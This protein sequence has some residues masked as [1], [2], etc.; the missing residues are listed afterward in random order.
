MIPKG[1]PK[2]LKQSLNVLNKIQGK[3]RVMVLSY[4]GAA[5][6]TMTFLP[7]KEPADLNHHWD[8]VRTL[9]EVPPP[10]GH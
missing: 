5:A 4:C 10:K 2:Q 1:L 3:T 8:D 6:S 7:R 9:G